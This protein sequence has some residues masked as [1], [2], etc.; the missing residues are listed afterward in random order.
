MKE[1]IIS[2]IV[3]ANQEHRDSKTI[4]TWNNI[5]RR[6]KASNEEEAIG[7]FI[8]Q[9][10]HIQASEKLMPGAILLDEITVLT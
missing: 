4:N 5:V 7:K 8:I 3:L 9:T 1:Y 2:Q 10:K 6:V